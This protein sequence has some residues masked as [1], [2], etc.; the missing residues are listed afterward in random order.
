MTEKIIR[1]QFVEDYYK[2]LI[3]KIARIDMYLSLNEYEYAYR[4]IKQIFAQINNAIKD[5]DQK[6]FNDLVDQLTTLDILIESYEL[7]KLQ[8]KEGR[9]YLIQLSK[10]RKFIDNKLYKLYTDIMAIMDRLNMLFPKQDKP[11]DA[12]TRF[13]EKYISNE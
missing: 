2:Y 8:E 7:S 10:Q 13:R 3:E 9:K 12:M 5:H 4:E 11:K 1:W 6:F